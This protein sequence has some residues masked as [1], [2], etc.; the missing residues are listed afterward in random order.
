VVEVDMPATAAKR[1]A[2]IKKLQWHKGN[3]AVISADLGTTPLS[4]VLETVAGWSHEAHTLIIAEGV[5]MYLSKKE[6]LAFLDTVS[7]HTRRGSRVVFSYLAADSDGRPS[8]GKWSALSRLSL[9][10]I[11]EP[12]KWGVREG[13]LQGF[14]EGAGYRLLGPPERYDFRERYLVPL[15]IDQPVGTIE[16][17]SIAESS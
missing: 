10:I 7:E 14:V 17:F 1:N 4:D 16:R 8:M 12:L 5:F 3:H 15:D 11:G 13:E 9:K 6:V 2:A